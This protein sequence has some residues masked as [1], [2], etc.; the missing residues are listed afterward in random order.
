MA[1]TVTVSY[2]LVA[3]DIVAFVRRSDRDLAVSYVA[4]MLT[5][6]HERGELAGRTENT[7]RVVEAVIAEWRAALDRQEP[8]KGPPHA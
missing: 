2:D 8:P 6:A 5:Q 4:M 7:D 3:A 1:S